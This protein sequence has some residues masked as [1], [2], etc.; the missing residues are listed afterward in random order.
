MLMGK[1]TSGP[2][3]RWEDDIKTGDEYNISRKHVNT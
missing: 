2:R 1:N 3:S